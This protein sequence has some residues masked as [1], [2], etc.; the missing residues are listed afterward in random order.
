MTINLY[1]ERNIAY[2][3]MLVLF[4]WGMVCGLIY[5]IYRSIREEEW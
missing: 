1:L 3:F 2:L 4:I 5:E